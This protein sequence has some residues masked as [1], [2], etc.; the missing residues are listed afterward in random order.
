VILYLLHDIAASVEHFFSIPD[1]W[2]DGLNNLGG[3]CSLSISDVAKKIASV[4]ARKI[5]ESILLKLW[6]KIIM[7]FIIRFNTI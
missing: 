3:N 6:E 2:K 7:R 4:Y 5:W 1:K